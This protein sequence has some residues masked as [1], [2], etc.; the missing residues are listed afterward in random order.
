MKAAMR[1]R[2]GRPRNINAPRER[3]GKIDRTWA[4]TQTERAAMETALA[5]RQRVFGLTERQARDA[6]AGTVIGRTMRPPRSAPEHIT[7]EQGDMATFYARVVHAYQCAIEAKP[8]AEP[9]PEQ[10]TGASHEDFCDHAIARF[11]EVLDVLRD[12][13]VARNSPNALSALD[14]FVIKDKFEISLV[15]DLRCALNELHRHFVVG[16]KRFSVD[17]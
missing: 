9:P 8:H 4:A 5:A 3:S 15:G 13:N 11:N 6:R 2:G 7:P 16:R 1:R 10:P 17:R 12:L 14:I